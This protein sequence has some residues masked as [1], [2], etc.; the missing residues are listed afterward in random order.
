MKFDPA[1]VSSPVFRFPRYATRHH[2]ICQKEKVLEFRVS[3][4]FSPAPAFLQLLQAFFGKTGINLYLGARGFV[5]VS[6]GL[7]GE[8][9]THGFP[10]PSRQ[11]K[12]FIRLFRKNLV[13]QEKRDGRMR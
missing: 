13:K 11:I 4:F 3:H 7:R 1:A 5:R 9:M 6:R 12:D 2:A 10:P 8:S